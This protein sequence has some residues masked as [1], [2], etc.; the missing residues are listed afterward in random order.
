[1]TRSGGCSADRPDRRVAARRRFA[2]AVAGALE[3]VLDQPGNVLLVFDDED[4]GV[5]IDARLKVSRAS[6]FCPWV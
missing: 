4:A 3:R 6:R 2:P 5:V 1:M